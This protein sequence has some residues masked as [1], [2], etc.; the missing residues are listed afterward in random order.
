V[1]LKVSVPSPKTLDTTVSVWQVL[2]IIHHLAHRLAAPAGNGGRSQPPGPAQLR[3]VRLLTAAPPQEPQAATAWPLHLPR[4]QPLGRPPLRR[5]PP[6][7]RRR[8]PASRGLLFL[9]VPVRP[10]LPR[11]RR[12]RLAPP[13]RLLQGQAVSHTRG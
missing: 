6:P 10:D 8:R 4:R 12:P 3:A 9:L 5:L 7:P 11:S 13:G 1:V 2:C